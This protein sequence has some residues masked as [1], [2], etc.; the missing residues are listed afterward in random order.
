MGAF[1]GMA[2]PDFPP[3]LNLIISTCKVCGRCQYR[4]FTTYPMNTPIA[5]WHEYPGSSEPKPTVSKTDEI[6]MADAVI[7]G[8]VIGVLMSIL[9]KP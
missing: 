1:S 6:S 2:P 4:A 3:E 7:I 8:L 5:F 9:A